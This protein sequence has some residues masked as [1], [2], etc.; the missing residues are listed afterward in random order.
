[1]KG[2]PIRVEVG[3]RDMED[4]IIMYSRRDKDGKT[5]LPIK[6]SADCLNQV[7]EDI[8]NSLFTQAK[9][10]QDDNTYTIETY[11]EFKSIINKGGFVICGWD[12][13]QD[14]EEKIKTETKATIRCI[15]FDQDV[16]NL[17]C[18]YSSNKAQ[19]KVI[20][21]KAY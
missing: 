8:Q 15:T 1:M 13:T 6:D 3:L 7:L 2:V 12:G 11:S 19:Y 4:D 16:N 21:S 5:K 20:F 9:K 14:T 17:K 10:F 18:I